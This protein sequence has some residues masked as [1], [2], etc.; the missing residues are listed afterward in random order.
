MSPMNC[1]A[2]TVNHAF[3]SR[4]RSNPHEG[5]QQN[6]ESHVNDELGSDITL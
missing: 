1:S 6:G 5:G 2:V 4:G 3:S